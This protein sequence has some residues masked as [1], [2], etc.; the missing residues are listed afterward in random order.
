MWIITIVTAIIIFATSTE[1]IQY[2]DGSISYFNETFNGQA[3]ERWE[4][5]S[6]RNAECI[7]GVGCDVPVT[8]DEPSIPLALIVILCSVV[9]YIL[10]Y[11]TVPFIGSVIWVL[12]GLGTSLLST[13]GDMAYFG[14]II[15]CIGVLTAF[16]SV[17]YTKGSNK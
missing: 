4:D 15:I 12:I 8:N 6:L 17:K 5:C 11:R 9:N 16:Y 7:Q 3:L 1:A 13:A 2:C 10:I 14:I